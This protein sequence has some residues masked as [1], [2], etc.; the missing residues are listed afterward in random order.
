[1]YDRL[2]A[3][4]TACQKK[5]L[6]RLPPVSALRA[7]AWNMQRKQIDRSSRIAS[8]MCDDVPY[9]RRRFVTCALGAFVAAGLPTERVRAEGARTGPWCRPM[10]KGASETSYD[11]N[12]Y[13]LDGEQRIFTLSA[14]LGKPVW[15]NFFTSWCPP[16]NSE[17]ADIVRIAHTY[18]DSAH[19]IGI[20]V[21]EKPEPVRAFRDKHRIPFPI[22]LD[23][24]GSVFK[25]L[26]LRGYPS[27]IFL[28]AAGRP[29]CLAVGD[30]TPDQMNNELAVAL[31]REVP[32]ARPT[33]APSATP[34]SSSTSSRGADPSPR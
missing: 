3:T 10:L 23:G 9:N 16:C 13:L 5:P 33:P 11:F 26:G 27:H 22:A 6:P 19:V 31:A 20:D 24:T 12:L 21:E 15:L 28:D 25:S 18:K 8:V 4:V 2:P 29:S 1:M 14:L 7:V 32:Q 17:A 30:L 34:G